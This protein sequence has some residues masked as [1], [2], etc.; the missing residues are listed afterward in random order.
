MDAITPALVSP[1]LPN[2]RGVITAIASDGKRTYIG[3]SSGYVIVYQRVTVV[4]EWEGRGSVKCLEVVGTVLVVGRS[5]GKEWRDG[6][7]LSTTVAYGVA[8]SSDEVSVAAMRG[9]T[10]RISNGAFPLTCVIDWL[11]G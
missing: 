8:P 6:V 11:V 7:A 1:P 3:T 4:A 10:E 9:A 2:G 5:G